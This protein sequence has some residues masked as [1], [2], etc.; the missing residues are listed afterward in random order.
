[1]LRL[2]GRGEDL[3]ALVVEQRDVR[4][5][6]FLAVADRGEPLPLVVGEVRLVGSLADALDLG[7]ELGALGDKARVQARLHGCSPCVRVGMDA[8]TRGPGL[9]RAG[10]DGLD[11]AARFAG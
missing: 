2:G 5:D 8:P 7:V 6:D 10:P 4:R 3:V 11:R 1:V 9:D